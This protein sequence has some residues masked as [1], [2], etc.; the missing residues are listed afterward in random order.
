MSSNGKGVSLQKRDSVRY[1]CKTKGLKKSHWYIFFILLFAQVTIAQNDRQ[2]RIYAQQAMAD[3]DWFGAVQYYGRLYFRDSSTISLKYKYAEASRLNLD[4]DVA[5]RLYTKVINEDN[6]RKYPMSFY[7]MGELLKYKSKYKDAKKWFTKFSKIKKKKNIKDFEYYLTKSKMQIE[8]CELAQILIKNPV[9]PPLE[10]LDKTINTKGSEYAPFEKD[11]VL[12]FSSLRD[13]G[14]KEANEVSYNKIYRSQIKNLKWQSVKALD[15]NVNSTYQHNANTCLSADGKQMVVSRCKTK[16]ATEYSCELYFGN[17]LNNKWQPLQKMPE[18]INLYGFNT[19]QPCFGEID[20]KQVLFFVSDRQGGSGNLDIWYSFINADQSFSEP[21][22]A[23]KLVNTPEDDIT[24]WFVSSQN[25]LYFSSTYHKGLGG[26]DIFKSVFND[27]VF[28]EAQNIGFPIN[29]SYNDVY[30]S[31]NKANTRAYLSSNRIGSFFEN[32]LNCCSDI[33]RF[34][35]NPLEAAKAPF[36]TITLIKEQMKLLVPLTLYFHNDEPDPKTKSNST[37]TN[38]ETTYS[39]YKTLLPQYTKEYGSGLKSKDKQSAGFKIENFFADSVDAGMA[40]LQKFTTLLE[41]L[42]KKGETVKITMKGYCSP[43]ASTEYNINLAKRRISSLRNYF[44]QHNQG[45]FLK[46]IDSV[47]DGQGKLIFENVEIGEL[48]TS[49]V[50]D[51]FKD[52]KNSIYSPYAAS[53]R[54]IQ[55]I[56]VSFGK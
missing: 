20:G 50:S 10:H 16:N 11:S 41:T 44:A 40:D 5:L 8:A 34:N 2:L 48:P 27:S 24:P 45:F 51:S 18:P 30:Y 12:Y 28:S 4:I 43:L 29:S 36:D 9:G 35:I 7:W 14:K 54:K 33:Y 23:G 55:V 47:V 26:F 21:I 42:M 38:Y 31:L 6:G 1:L 22:N 52:K 56:A 3:K 19:T 53:E 49:K 17:Y 37:T 25:A 46:Y 13:I 39:A 15:T 32:K